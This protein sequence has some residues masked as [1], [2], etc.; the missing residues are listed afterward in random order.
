MVRIRLQRKGRKN[1]PAYRVVAAD[2]KS[3]RDGKF[4]EII[5]HY[6]PTENPDKFDY[7]KDRYEYW[8]NTGAQPSSAV[9]KLVSSKYKYEPYDAKKLKELKE[10]QAA[11]L[12]A[13][14]AAKKEPTK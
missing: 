9:K 14:Q 13:Q 3:P 2:I 6:N 1:A 12:A 11:D 4:L 10:K 5:G 8:V 7:K